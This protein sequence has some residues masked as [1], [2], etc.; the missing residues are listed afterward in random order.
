VSLVALISGRTSNRSIVLSKSLGTIDLNDFLE[1]L[2][3]VL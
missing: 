3:M 1:T 2:E